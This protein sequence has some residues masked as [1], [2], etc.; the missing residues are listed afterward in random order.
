[1]DNQGLFIARRHVLASAIISV[2]S[3]P[4]IA[5]EQPKASGE[6][7]TMQVT[8]QGKT[9]LDAF[10]GEQEISKTQAN[11][12][13][14]L[15][16]HTPGVDVG[17]SP[18]IA[19]KIYVR[20][21]ED[22]MLNVSIDGATQ[23]GSLFHHQGR[24][25][26]EP[27]LLKAVE[28]QAGAGDAT[29]GPGALGGAI[30]FITKDPSD[31]LQQG[32]RF[33]ALVK[34]GYYSNTQGY[35]TSAT[36]YGKATDSWS[37]MGVFT[38]A[39]G[40][41][42]KD[43]QGNKVANTGS[44][45]TIGFAKLVGELTDSQTV[46][47]SYDRRDDEGTRTQRPQW[48]ESKWNKAYLLKSK[49][50]SYNLKYH[51]APLDNDYLD[52]TATLYNTYSQ[53]DQ[54]VVDRWGKYRGKVDSIGFDLRNISLIADHQL[55]YGLDYRKDKAQGYAVGSSNDRRQ[56]EKADVTGLYLQDYYQLTQSL[57]LGFG[58]RYDIYDLTDVKNQTFKEKGFSPN[59]SASYQVI[60]D[61]SVRASYAEAFRGKL[62]GSSFKLDSA[63][64]D[65]N[66]KPERAKNSELG[67]DY[68]YDA[69][70]LTAT[71]YK[72]RIKDAISDVKR[73]YKNIGDIEI[74]GFNARTSY[75]WRDVVAGLGFS[76][77]KSELDDKPMNAYDHGFL[78]NSVG[79]TWLA[80][81]RYQL[82]SQLE[83]GWNGKLVNSLDNIETSAGNMDKP[84]YQVHDIYAQWLPLDS[85]DL[86]VTL[87]IKNLFDEYYLDH[88]SNGDFEH[89]PGFKGVVGLHSP[90]RD[91]RL[92]LA[93]NF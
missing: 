7:E 13:S 62:T 82:N 24:I 71:V 87:T 39:D 67:F 57:R 11:D 80:D 69:F 77:N 47:F 43:G 2:L 41:D 27:E 17:G 38:K 50:E 85:G 3:Y 26:I 22:S 36:L 52:L 46:S 58:G 68:N 76:H 1:M 37:A 21:L 34:G 32:E 86:K 5:E 19:Q 8:G 51:L 49:R 18:S 29:S 55:T 63:A 92:G 9:G 91:I 88:A 16:S 12:L 78:G 45:Q 33:G 40:E 73:V 72:S 48:I 25:F 93:Y 59:V 20:G 60:P 35:K 81:I 70:N 28:V 53:V 31:L 30:R 90:G 14:D 75:A 10:I 66:L 79:D 89:L 44:E 84:G 74:Q 83:F 6:V 64:N 42:M 65:P 23:G 61:L 15:F 54:D 56:E 4:A